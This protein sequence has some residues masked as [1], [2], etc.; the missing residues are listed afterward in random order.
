M[1][2]LIR[3]NKPIIHKPKISSSMMKS[4]LLI[5]I[6]LLAYAP[7]ILALPEDQQQILELSAN[8]ADLNQETRHG[9]YIGAVELNQGTTHLRA[10]KAITNT[11]AHNKLIVAIATG[12]SKNQ[13][14]YWTQTALDK[15]MMHAYADTINYYPERHLI[16]L[17]G[18]ARVEQGNNSFSAAKITYDTLKQHVLSEADTQNRTVIIF[19]PEPHPI[20][21]KKS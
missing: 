13:V 15:P 14:H 12:D 11:D 3:N 9:E 21:G 5:G 6:T 10:T 1:R 18:H 16:E 7:A 8:T 19:H 17:I 2:H 20:Q 4:G